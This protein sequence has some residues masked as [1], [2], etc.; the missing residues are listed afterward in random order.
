MNYNEIKV[1]EGVARCIGAGNYPI[2]PEYMG[3]DKKLNFL[4]DQLELN[5]RSKRT[6]VHISLNF[7]PSESNLSEEKLVQIADGYMDKIGFGNQPYLIYQHFDAGHPH[8]HIVSI[9]IQRDATR[10][11]MTNI[12]KLKS[13]PARKELEKDFGLVRAEDHC[14]E[15]AY[16]PEPID[17]TAVEYGRLETKKAIQNVLE[18]VLEQYNYTS[19]PELNALLGRYNISA[20]IGE[21]G[22]R[23]HAHQ[24]LL[25]RIID[26]NGKPIG[27][28]I[29]ASAF[30]NRP[31]LKKLRENFDRGTVK[32]MP[33]RTRLKATIDRVLADGQLPLGAFVEQISQKG[34]DVVFRM[35]DEEFIFGVTY[36][37]HVSKCVF[38]GSALG[39]NYSAKAIQE[40]C[41]PS[42]GRSTGKAQQTVVRESMGN[43]ATVKQNTYSF[44][45]GLDPYW[46]GRSFMHELVHNLTQ[47]ENTTEYIPYE[48]SMNKKKKRKKRK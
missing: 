22:S 38:N 46:K 11:N 14:M 40:R 20:Y 44:I 43:Q 27:I 28:P 34:I 42:A 21:E 4:R 45:P 36:V 10:I 9:N 13:E 32:R 25:F 41:V 15:L 23:V 35:N 12:A 3:F 2:D 7:D 39:K 29:K 17:L 5:L 26:T 33:Y 8:L 48:F 18:H 37:D 6:S 31:T 16:R 47:F 1:R 30:Y 19:L 24:G